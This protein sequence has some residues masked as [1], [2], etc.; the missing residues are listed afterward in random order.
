MIIG[1]EINADLFLDLDTT[2]D[3]GKL[4]PEMVSSAS[5]ARF[6]SLLDS[7]DVTVNGDRPWDVTVHDDLFFRRVA[8]DGLL[9]LGESYVDGLWD[10]RDID[11]LFD[12]CLHADIP[13]KLRFSRPVVLRYLRERFFNLQSVRGAWRNGRAHYNLGNDLFEASLDRRLAY[14]CAYWDGAASLDEAQE[15]KLELV[16]RKLGLEQGMR[17]LDI[18]SGWGS[19]VGYAAE[20]FGCEMVGVTV[21]ERQAEF[22]RRRY[23]GLP[24]E[25]RLQDYRTLNEKFDRVVSI[26]MFEHV[27]PKNYRAYMRI[28]HRCLGENGLALL[29]FFATQRPWPNLL[30]S[31]MLWIT[32]YIFPGL[33]VP[34]LGQVGSAVDGLFVTEDLHNFGADYDRTLMEW[35]ANF[36]RNWPTIQAHYGERFYR[37]WKYYLLSCAGAFRARKYQL[38]QLV[39]SASGVPGGY[40]PVRVT[41][42]PPV[43]VADEPA[44][45]PSA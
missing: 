27:G 2:P 39:L 15:Q 41:A 20:H 18:G 30:D 9:G 44:I 37:L 22:T 11:Q 1:L 17:V 21:S 14:S 10:C 45:A 4:E 31:E 6:S 3:V 43:L 34:T 16:C 28:V 24:V 13:S 40:R 19:F 8:R 33:V 38:W 12:R 5:I 32:R 36:D 29:H 26:G 23:K 7:A 25:I 35:F 42:Q